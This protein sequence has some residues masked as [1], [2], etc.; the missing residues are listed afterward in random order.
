MHQMSSIVPILNDANRYSGKQF[1]ERLTTSS[2]LRI[3]EMPRYS[4]AINYFL[5]RFNRAVRLAYTSSL[6]ANSSR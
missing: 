1:S 3:C 5:S 4:A 6:I 2:L